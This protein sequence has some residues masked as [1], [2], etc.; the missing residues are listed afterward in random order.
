MTRSYAEKLDNVRRSFSLRSP[1]KSNGVHAI[2]RPRAAAEVSDAKIVRGRLAGR[3]HGQDIDGAGAESADGEQCARAVVQLQVEV[4]RGI[5][6]QGRGQ[7]TSGGPDHFE[8]VAV[9]TAGDRR[10]DDGVSVGNRLR[11]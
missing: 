3:C 11:G 6:D 5:R 4:R 8:V 9:G 7:R 2:S 10:V 1:V